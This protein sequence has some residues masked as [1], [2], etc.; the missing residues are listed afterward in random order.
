MKRASERQITKDDS[1]SGDDSADGMKE[2]IQKASAE[3]ISKRK[4]VRA[5]RSVTA[6]PNAAPAPKSNPFAAFSGATKAKE[7]VAKAPSPPESEVVS[8]PAVKEDAPAAAVK[9]SPADAEPDLAAAPS[10]KEIERTVG[11][12]AEAA[13]AAEAAAGEAAVYK[14]AGAPAAVDSE[15]TP[16]NTVNETVEA[17]KEQTVVD[18]EA[19]VEK[20]TEWK[21]ADESAGST[22]DDKA[23]EASPAAAGDPVEAGKEVGKGD[24]HGAPSTP[25][26][27]GGDAEKPVLAPGHAKAVT[28]KDKEDPLPDQASNGEAA[29]KPAFSFGGIGG[30]VTGK[31]FGDAAASASGFKFSTAPP[32]SNGEPA[33]APPKAGA[34]PGEASSGGKFVKTDVITGEEEEEEVF[35]ARCKLYILEDGS[36]WKERGV[37]YLKLNAHTKTKK[38]RLLMRTEGTF[39]VILNTPATKSLTM[40]RASERSVRFQGLSVEEDKDSN[41]STFLARFGSKD[42]LDT[43]LSTL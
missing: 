32:V 38:S 25:A 8:A 3:V 40:D 10:E 35:R 7:S 37:G 16:Q 31:S 30:G 1:D 6:G 15:S 12:T 39:R 43:L 22:K 2:G 21:R 28:E 33:G 11:T 18:S 9:A 19:K 5:R 36:K 34:L 27:N 41:Y 23:T 17:A 4:I 20:E 26:S 42:D 14:N 13:L 24:G 29:K